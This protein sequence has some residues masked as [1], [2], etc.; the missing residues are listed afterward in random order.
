MLEEIDTGLAL[1]QEALVSDDFLPVELSPERPSSDQFPY[2]MDTITIPFTWSKPRRQ[3]PDPL[4]RLGQRDEAWE[5]QRAWMLKDAQLTSTQIALSALETLRDDFLRFYHRDAGTAAA[6]GTSTHGQ[7]VSACQGQGQG[8]LTAACSAFT[9]LRRTSPAARC[10][11]CR[12]QAGG[13]TV[14]Q[15][16]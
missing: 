7:I 4:N 8:R 3:G 15:E 9:R 6:D 14:I 13:L 1:S 12:A 16:R 11:A 5:R 2:G 10:R